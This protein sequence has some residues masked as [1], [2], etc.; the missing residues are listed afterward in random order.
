MSISF[1]ELSE[2]VTAREFAETAL[3]MRNGRIRCPFRDGHA[4]HDFNVGFTP[5]GHAHCFV[6]GRTA[7]AV[8]LAAAVWNVAQVEAAAELNSMFNLG[9]DRKTATDADK[10]RWRAERQRRNNKYQAAEDAVADA[11]EEAQ[12]AWAAVEA[13]DP[14][15]AEYAELRHQAENADLWTSFKLMELQ[16]M[17]AAAGRC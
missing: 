11:Q 2:L 10:K 3:E 5:D 7:D 9:L 15:S 13:A 16:L 4:G 14:D 17:T 12:L 1:R 6:C 8:Q